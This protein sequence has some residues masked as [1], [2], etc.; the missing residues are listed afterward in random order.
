MAGIS[1]RRFL[2]RYVTVKYAVG[3]LGLEE[4]SGCLDEVSEDY[5][6]LVNEYGD[7]I[8]LVGVGIYKVVVHRECAGGRGG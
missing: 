7:E 6:K 1:L 8:Y 2:G 5:V 4:D 3:E